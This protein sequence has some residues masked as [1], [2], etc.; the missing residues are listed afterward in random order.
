MSIQALAGV[1]QPGAPFNG[2][3]GRRPAPLPL[4]AVGDGGVGSVA[5]ASLD[6]ADI[7]RQLRSGESV[8][9]VAA[10]KGVP[11]AKI[12]EAIMTLMLPN[13]DRNGDIAE[14]I[15]LHRTLPIKHKAREPQPESDPIAR[16][17][18]AMQDA[19]LP[20]HA[21]RVAEAAQQMVP[22]SHA[23]NSVT[24]NVLNATAPSHM[25]QPSAIDHESLSARSIDTY[26]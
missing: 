14:R 18:A 4:D 9:A 16:H 19:T 24:T 21:A 11:A 7:D 6:V 23:T 2:A 26:V 13:A 8:A 25:V 20:G 22:G 5:A 3:S 12:I 1:S 17:E 10:A 15:A